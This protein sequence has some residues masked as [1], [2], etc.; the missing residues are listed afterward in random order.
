MRRARGRKLAIAVAWLAA[1]LVPSAPK[2]DAQQLAELLPF[3][4]DWGDAAARARTD[5]KLVLAIVQI[6]PG[7]VI[8]ADASVGCF[9]EQ[10]LLDLVRERFVPLHV[11]RA[12]SVPF[13]AA[14]RYGMGPNCFGASALVVTADGDVVGDTFVVSSATAWLDEFLRGVLA[15]RAQDE[16]DGSAIAEPIERA[17]AFARRGE[18]EEARVA[19]R[20]VETLRG[21]LLRA[22]IHRRLREGEAARAELA[23][24][25]A[26]TAKE[27]AG[28]DLRVEIEIE[29]A[30]VAAGTGD[31]AE[32]RAAFGRALAL[33]PAGPRAAEI[34]MQLA[35]LAWCERDYPTARR[36]F[37][38]VVS[39][40]PGTF[41]ASSA[42][43]QL[44]DPGFELG[45]AV[46]P[47]FTSDDVMNALTLAAP[48]PLPRSDAAR[49]E[50]DAV[51]RLLADQRSDGSWVV[52]T[53]VA[54]AR[55]DRPDPL[56]IAVTAIAAQSLL[57][58]RGDARV[59]QALR[60][61]LPWLLAQSRRARSSPAARESFDYW[62]WGYAYLV[63]FLADAVESGFVPIAELGGE[64]EMLFADLAARQQSGGGWS[65]FLS[66]DPAQMDR[67]L[68]ISI[69]F[70]TGAIVAALQHAGDAGMAVPRE[71][72]D[73]AVACLEA[74]RVRG[75][76]FR[77]GADPAAPAP[78][79]PMES[80]GAA[81]RDAFL[82]HV[83][84]RA[85][86]GHTG[87]VERAL[88]RF[89]DHLDEIAR[90]QGKSLMHCGPEALGSHYVFFDYANTARLLSERGLK[91]KLRGELLDRVLAARLA[92]GS[93]L[94]NPLIGRA[95]GTAMAL[96]ALRFLRDAPPFERPAFERI[97]LDDHVGIGYGVAVA[98]VDGDGRRDVLLVDQHE[99]RWHR[100][101][102][103]EAHKLC[104]PLTEL[105]HVCVAAR[106]GTAGKPASIAIGAGWNPG[107]TVNSGALFRLE[108]TADP[109]QPWTPIE[110]PRE[111]TVHRMKWLRRGDEVGLFVL[112]L[113]GR[114]NVDGEGEGVRALDGLPPRAGETAW[115]T[116][117]WETP[118]HQCHNLDVVEWDGDD[119]DELLIASR[120][121]L[122]LCDGPS[123][124]GGPWL[125][126][127]L[128]GP[129]LGQ[130]DFR[131]AS[132][133]RLGR[134]GNGRRFLATIEPFHGNALVVYVE[135]ARELEPWT[136]VVV[137]ESLADGHAL[138]CGDLF[139]RGDDQIV[140]GWRKPDR[141]GRTGIRIFTPAPFTASDAGPP[142]FDMEELD[143]RIA[144]EDLAL[145]D[146]DL[147]GRLDVVAS[148]RDSHDLVLFLNR[149]PPRAAAT[150][151]R[152]PLDV[153]RLAAID[154]VVAEALAQRKLPGCVVAIG[155]GDGLRFM[156]AYGDRS[157]VP[158]REAMTVDTLFDLASLTKPIATATCL[159]LLADE[160]KLALDDPLSKLL[161]EFTGTVTLRQC[162]LHVAGFAP[163]NEIADYEEGVDAAWRRL[164]AQIPASEP[165]SW[166]VYSDVGYELLGK[167]VERVSGQSLADFTRRRLFTPLAMNESGFLPD[168]NLKS[169]AAPTEPRDGA[170]LEGVVHDP[171]AARL[172]GVAGHAGLFSTARDLARYARMLLNR[173]ELDGARVL[174]SDGVA[175]LTTA[176]SVAGGGRRTPGFDAHSRF[177]S[178][179]GELMTSR[180]FGHGGFTGTGLWI[181][182]GL[183]LFVIFLSNR[184][185]PDGKGSVNPLI[186]RIGTIAS[187]AVGR[188]R[189][190]RAPVRLGVDLL[191]AGGFESLRGRRVGL[192]TNHSGRASDGTSTIRLL[193]G[194]AAR[195]AGVALVAIFTPEHG[196][197]G[198]QDAAVK[199]GVEASSG[200]PVRSLYGE[201]TRP[202]PEM[203][204]GIDTLVFDVQDAGARCYTYVTT[205][206]R[207]ME[208]AAEHGL[209]FV[210]LDRPD[211]IGGEVVAGP[212]PDSGRESFTNYHSIPFRHGMTVGELA[213]MFR[214]E[215]LPSVVG[216]E[217]ATALA[218]DVVAMEGWRRR[219]EF[220]AT[221]LPWVN[222][223]PNLRS[224]DE[225]R[226]YPGLV[227][228]EPTN[229]SVGRGTDSPFEQIGAPWL[230]AKAVVADLATRSLPGARVT[231]VEFTPTSSTLAGEPCRGLR[232]TITDRV[233]LEP[234]HV[235]LE[236]A[237]A[238][239]RRHPREW[240]LEKMDTLL[241]S[242]ATIDAL[243][244]GAST[245]TILAR[246]QADAA[247]FRERRQPF[248]LYE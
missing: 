104:G 61:A 221:G 237:E 122:Y 22:R 3:A 49:A 197:D 11:T 126:S 185:H 102:K 136:R 220:D 193:A 56:R 157:L 141:S 41:W 63:W 189:E 133:V 222:P 201:R 160:G 47:R 109:L 80:T 78:L 219:D 211:P 207:C 173:G 45:V 148:G 14:D 110:L 71:L 92:D 242:R 149:A 55:V 146:L 176:E 161:P 90:E 230:D 85:G 24:A 15:E 236:I 9:L 175:R 86:R 143:D 8:P 155:R 75:D 135:P 150:A 240:E 246:W 1:A 223:S 156:R 48:A 13:A 224:L 123:T 79:A 235:A 112:P 72:L 57:P 18:L 233:A 134:F 35:S 194:D 46:D 145:A 216:A 88:R 245:D 163:D 228:F 58:E 74:M 37:G 32:A 238:I 243:R 28:A 225:A 26:L 99:V 10:E 137:D 87:A 188:P 179:R 43:A 169:R 206:G 164:F 132:E 36:L 234:M 64:P 212:L 19:A 178:N 97:V 42:A 130:P 5:R 172:G 50:R 94:D 192:V 111:P 44:A 226:L 73:R 209:R 208:A 171:R 68:P 202:T 231:A 142:R 119:D 154:G 140:V 214:A 105:D 106:D 218:L 158:A 239:A 147:D 127:Q 183:D 33:A 108:P 20:G 83:L 69:S 53:D 96:Q 82:C 205:L 153:A 30:A 199:D 186:G 95:Y 17:E 152:A 204:A 117:L 170:M 195:A 187:S 151:E 128:V 27:N 91:V 227:L 93:F 198:A 118:L 177:S 124:S 162:L 165:G 23:R 62:P 2:A 65:Y 121:G 139:G 21:C 248:L 241:C 217:K 34:E 4:K 67:P 125:A 200:V 129:A 116:R 103:W 120:E 229:L 184:V 100:A 66:A 144:C 191:R 203:L 25:D 84:E 182:P 89:G 159:E 196:L 215:K 167:V 77:Y 39:G 247:T 29:R 98:D 52:G 101:P 40:H 51:A 213:R 131:G 232:V 38:E 76:S 81:G 114:G 60:R 168:A 244:A 107:D 54:L 138:A 166:F 16:W 174:S 7:L 210:V 181:D 6:Y 180:A 31:V 190:A 70:I 113:H 12:D 59:E 115:R